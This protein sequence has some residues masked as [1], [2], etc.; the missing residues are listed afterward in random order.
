MPRLLN[1]RILITREKKQ[2]QI[3]SEKILRSGGIPIE[4][5]LLKISCKDKDKIKNN[6]IFNELGRYQWIFFTSA[7]GVDCFFKLINTDIFNVLASS[8]IAVV[9]HKTELA[10]KKHG[11]HADFIPTTYNAEVMASEFLAKHPT[12]RPLLLVRGN[13]SRTVLPFQ[14]SNYGLTFDLVEVY[15]TSYN[16]DIKKTLNKYM[17]ED[18]IDFITFT[19]PSTVDA[20]M[21]MTAERSFHDKVCVCIG[22]TTEKRAQEYGF[23]TTIVPDQFTIEGMID[24]M[25]DHL[26]MKKG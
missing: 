18:E 4:V 19:S 11:F 14:F 12:N 3:F 23:K 25:S 10:L 20:F 9:G 8:K 16:L 17:I 15:E 22:T 13:R 7:N 2:S 1:K 6:Y 26:V 21:K 5:P 24:C